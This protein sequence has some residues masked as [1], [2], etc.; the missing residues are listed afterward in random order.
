MNQDFEERIAG[1]RVGIELYV[2]GST[3]GT[4]DRSPS[5]A[6]AKETV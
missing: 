1:D 4:G 3:T 6:F 5:P 2:C